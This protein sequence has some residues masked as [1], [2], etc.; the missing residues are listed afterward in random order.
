MVPPPKLL[1]CQLTHS[2][3]AR[4]HYSKHMKP[5]RLAFR[6]EHPRYLNPFEGRRKRIPLSGLFLFD[7]EVP[8]RLQGMSFRSAFAQIGQESLYKGL[9]RVEK[10]G[11]ASASIRNRLRT[12]L[13]GP[14]GN[15]LA[16]L[17]DAPH[18]ST[19]R[20][21]QMGPWELFLS[22]ASEAGREEGAAWPRLGQ[23][24]RSIERGSRD[25][26][27]LFASGQGQSGSDY[28]A[29]QP[30]LR[31]FLPPEF[32]YGMAQTKSID[33]LLPFRVTTSLEVWLS[34]IALWDIESRPNDNDDTRSIVIRLLDHSQNGTRN[35]AAQLFH[36][37]RTTAGVKSTAELVADSRLTPLNA[38]IGTL[39]T[40]SRGEHFPSV[41]YGRAYA[42]ALLSQE[43]T[44]EFNMLLTASR[45][46]NFL[47]YIAQRQE[48]SFEWRERRGDTR[49]RPQGNGLPF[50]FE[51]I[52]AWMRN[53]F[54]AWLRFHRMPSE[55][56]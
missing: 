48:E 49:P 27:T 37:L 28:L 36:W 53:R 15:E 54:Q 29:R 52:D 40:W 43:D 22:A 26:V 11:R 31:H 20:I 6:R 41:S 56:G 17:L 44:T 2:G 47:G 1:H 45:H 33:E 51:S 46:L 23:F 21:A 25:A 55:T 8:M 16:S 30:L 19:H 14:F 38:Q 32:L 18:D 34:L 12:L 3:R 7:P 10:T 42:R 24:I 35:S 5:D 4:R 39:G 13:P 50:G 9:E